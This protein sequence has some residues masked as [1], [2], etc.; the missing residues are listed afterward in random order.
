METLVC[1]RCGEE[2]P[3]ADFPPLKT[4]FAFTKSYVKHCRKCN[5]ELAREWR[6]KNPGNKGSGK[7]AK[8]PPEERKWMSA[9]RFRLTSARM[10]CKKLGRAEPEVSAEYLYNLLLQQNK[11]CALTGAMLSLEKTDPLCLSLDQIQPNKGYVEGNV[12]W[13]CWDVNFAKGEL[14]QEDFVDLCK[15]VVN[16]SKIS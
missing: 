10:R 12:Q 2:K 4:N 5:N 8:L 14:A 15:A 9:V 1:K 16:K 7:V 6:K 13:L 3:I 11:Q